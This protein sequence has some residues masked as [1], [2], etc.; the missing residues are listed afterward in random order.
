M[1]ERRAARIGATFPGVLEP[2]PHDSPAV[3][4]VSNFG[5]SPW[6]D[7]NGVAAQPS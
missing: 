4:C 7:S 6:S 1:A 2:L 3:L 5:G